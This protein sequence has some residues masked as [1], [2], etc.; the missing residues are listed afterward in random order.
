MKAVD[1]DITLQ[2]FLFRDQN[3]P[4]RLS[5]SLDYGEHERQQ[6]SSTF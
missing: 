1:A 5:D 3:L 6:L 2:K 4:K